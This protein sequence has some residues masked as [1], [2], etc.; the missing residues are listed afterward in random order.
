[1][2]IAAT[3]S[4]RSARRAAR[5]GLMSSCIPAPTP[6]GHT[7]GVVLEPSI[8][9][10]CGTDGQLSPHLSPK[11]LT[12][13]IPLAEGERLFTRG[14]QPVFENRSLSFIKPVL[15]ICGGFTEL[16]DLRMAAVYDIA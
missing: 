8:D 5:F 6:T 9:F 1:M 4:R 11:Y 10:S 3:A 14:I 7:D 12:K 15:C 13:S 2:E 16:K